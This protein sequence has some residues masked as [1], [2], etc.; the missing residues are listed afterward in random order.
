MELLK[1]WISGTTLSRATTRAANTTT[2]SPSP[3][4]QEKRW[5][6]TEKFWKILKNRKILK[7]TSKYRN[8]QQNTENTTICRP[9]RSRQGC[10]Q[11]IYQI[12]NERQI[13]S[14]LIFTY[15][16]RLLPW[17]GNHYIHTL[18][19]DSNRN[20]Y[21]SIYCRALRNQAAVCWRLR[22]RSFWGRRWS[23]WWWWWS[24]WSWWWWWSGCWVHDHWYVYDQQCKSLDI[25]VVVDVL[26]VS[27]VFARWRTTTLA[28]KTEIMM[29]MMMSC[30]FRSW[31]WCLWPT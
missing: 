3:N 12:S 4:R 17:Q 22:S 8:I 24:S 27:M 11:S 13:R 6:N 1:I 19:Q 10:K 18:Q 28:T 20:R 29:I 5:K 25:L 15:I 2:C 16:Y 14:I 31:S 26:M 9:S 23:W 21:L 30:A 7:N